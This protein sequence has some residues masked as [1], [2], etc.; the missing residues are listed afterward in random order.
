MK[1]KDHAAEIGLVTYDGV[2]QI[3]YNHAEL[4]KYVEEK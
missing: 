1:E 2:D 4:G 3:S